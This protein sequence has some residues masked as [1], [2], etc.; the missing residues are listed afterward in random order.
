MKYL[1]M[2][3]AATAFISTA[4]A[5]SRLAD[6]CTGGACCMVDLGCCH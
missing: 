6:C 2:I 5:T 4:S 3:L 1:L